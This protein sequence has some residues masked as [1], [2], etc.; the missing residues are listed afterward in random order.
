YVG[1]NNF[2]GSNPDILKFDGTNWTV[3]GPGIAGSFSWVTDLQVYNNR[4]YIGGYFEQSAGNAGDF[5][6]YWDGGTSYKKVFNFID[7]YVCSLD[8]FNGKL[9][10]AGTFENIN[11][12]HTGNIVG[13]DSLTFCTLS[14]P[15]VTNV[16]TQIQKWNNTFLITGGFTTIDTTN[17]ECLAVWDGGN[18]TD[19]CAFTVGVK[20]LELKELN[21]SLYPNPANEILNVS[22][23]F[24]NETKIQITDLT[25]KIISET[26]VE[27][28]AGKTIQPLNISALSKGIYFVNLISEGKNFCK[29]FIK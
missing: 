21:I 24:Q 2:S 7:Y 28:T 20:E 27:N 17:F 26:R 19:T 6:M 25:G 15:P 11:G 13:I 8:T 3:P 22:F 9:L 16:I 10:V 29:K 23:E 14:N 1:G 5:L 12:I 4:L 18:Y